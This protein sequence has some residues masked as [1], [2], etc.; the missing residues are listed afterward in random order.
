M[1]DIVEDLQK[2]RNKEE[3]NMGDDVPCIIA[4]HVSAASNQG[5]S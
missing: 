1:T 5:A 3:T 4:H 2:G